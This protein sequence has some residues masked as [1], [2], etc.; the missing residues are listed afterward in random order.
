MSIHPRLSPFSTNTHI[1]SKGLVFTSFS[2]DRIPPAKLFS[3]NGL[4]LRIFSS[5]AMAFLE[6]PS[7]ARKTKV[8]TP[9]VFR[10]SRREIFFSSAYSMLLFLFLSYI[11][12]S[13]NNRDVASMS[14]RI[15]YDT[16]MFINEKSDNE[17]VFFQI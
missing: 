8:L 2:N 11:R 10:N 15:I 13:Y 1:R 16:Y 14:M 17:Y 3:I 5:F 6:K 4:S 9:V 12:K 7:S